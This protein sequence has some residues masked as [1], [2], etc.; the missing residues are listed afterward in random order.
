MPFGRTRRSAPTQTIST[1]K[2]QPSD[3]VTPVFVGT[4]DRASLQIVTRHGVPT[5]RYTS[6]CTTTDARPC[7]PTTGYTSRRSDTSLHVTASRHIATRHD[8]PT[9]RYTSS[10]SFQRWKLLFP[11]LEKEISSLGK[12]NFHRWK[13]YFP[14][15]ESFWKTNTLRK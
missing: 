10:V 4:H 1:R 15:V 14:R 6:C 2:V 11:A 9:H 3:A 7:V 12:N 8:V 5:H 13:F